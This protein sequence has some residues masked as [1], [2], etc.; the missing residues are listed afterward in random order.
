VSPPRIDQLLLLLLLLR[1]AQVVVM[2]MGWAN[3]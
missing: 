1:G 3:D 2:V